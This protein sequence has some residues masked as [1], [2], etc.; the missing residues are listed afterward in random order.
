MSLP[1]T[2]RSLLSSR[3]QAVLLATAICIGSI[4]PLQEAFAA[5]VTS[6]PFVEKP[7][8][9]E[10]RKPPPP[11]KAEDR[12]PDLSGTYRIMA[13]LNPDGSRYDG[14]VIIR[15]AGGEKTGY[16]LK[17]AIGT[18][19]QEES[20]CGSVTIGAGGNPILTVDWGS[21]Y[22]VVYEVSDDGKSLAGLWHDGA[23]KE[24]LERR[25]PLPAKAEDRLPDLSGTYRIAA[26]VNPDGSRYD[27]TVTISRAGGK[28]MA[29][30]LKWAIGT[31]GQEE[32]GCGGVTVGA[33]GKLILTVDWGSDYPVIY[34]VSGDG[35][36]FAGLWHN[37]AGKE[38][39]VR[40]S[41][42]VTTGREG[43]TTAPARKTFL[44]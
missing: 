42:P 16:C 26:G 6:N 32:S 3:W 35:K 31:E 14:T 29:Y 20:G 28:K 17:W 27:G 37:G 33:G 12:L 10:E 21:A 7:R 41:G 24:D 38:D 9:A 43:G 4:A 40:V 23:G 25:G 11:A 39:L 1:P 30:C 36:S 34:E 18:G 13:G 5:S 22:P 8:P 2:Q 44:R 15:R 19:G